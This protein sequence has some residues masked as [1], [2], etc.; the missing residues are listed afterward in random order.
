MR[1]QAL[2]KLEKGGWPSEGIWRRKSPEATGGREARKGGKTGISGLGW[3]SLV[4]PALI[5]P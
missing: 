4:K 5:L 3:K 2:G 1:C